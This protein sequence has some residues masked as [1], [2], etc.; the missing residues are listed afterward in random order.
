MTRPQGVWAKHIAALKENPEMA[1]PLLEI[2]KSDLSKYVQDSVGNW[3]NDAEK[4]QPEWVLQ[5]CRTWE[6]ESRT[7]ET[8][9]ILKRAQRSLTNK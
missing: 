5:V 2:V 8:M 9:R 6:E 4:S 7:K 3:L 1:L